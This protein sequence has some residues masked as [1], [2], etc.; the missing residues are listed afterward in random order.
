MDNIL[1]TPSEIEPVT[2]DEIKCYLD[3]A[4]N[5][6]DETLNRLIS[7][8]REIIEKYLGLSLTTQTRKQTLDANEYK[9][10]IRLWYSPIQSITSVT[11]YDIDNNASIW[12]AS[13]YYLYNNYLNLNYTSSIDITL[14]ERNSIEILYI[15]GYGDSIDSVPQSI[16]QSIID[17]ICF[18]FECGEG[19]AVTLPDKV[20]QQLSGFRNVGA[21]LLS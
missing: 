8:C 13:N 19:A 21:Y 15:S 18:I 2:L 17:Y 6:H 11:L 7:S 3:I 4:D 10:K 20:K 1:V 9:E 12:N 5:T 14:R 16:R